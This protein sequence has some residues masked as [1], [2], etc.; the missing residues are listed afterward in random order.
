MTTTRLLA[1][2]LGLAA[3][4]TVATAPFAQAEPGLELT[5][6][7]PTG[8]HAIGTTSLHLVDHDRP[9]P[10]RPD[11]AREL[12]VTVTYPARHQS[13]DRAPW[14]SRAVAETVDSF[15]F[16]GQESPVTWHRTRR[17]AGESAPVDRARGGLPVVLFSPGL[18]VPRELNTVVTDDLA[19]RGYLVVSMSHTYETT[20]VEFPGGRVE[21]ADGTMDLK[22]SL[23]AR[24]GDTRF[25]LDKLTELDR[26]RNPDAGHRRL[27][28]GL[29][30]SLDL[31]RVGMFGHSYGGFTTAETMH[32]DRRID[33]GI[34][35]DGTMN[36]S[37][38]GQYLPGEVVKNG[39]DR[40]FALVGSTFLTPDG[41]RAD[42]NHLPGGLDRSW[43][44]FWANQQGWKRDL[45]VVDAGHNSFTDPQALMD[46][47]GPLLP[48][49]MRVALVGTIDPARSMAVQHNYL[50]AFFDLHLRGRDNH[51]LDGP[52]PAYPEV[53]FV[54]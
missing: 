44:E 25:V 14:M 2:G 33:A 32:Y 50:S 43:A 16:P 8:R 3:A 23:D 40:P 12:M 53:L 1:L 27:P 17:H 21:K 13:R 31:T 7:H 48:E 30:G 4:A 19:S 5:L 35:L 42:H 20:A 18:S 49:D 39:L 41:Q 47:L 11:R 46:Q 34:N 38:D 52:S 45:T 28:A 24:V 6:P 36:Y 9:D 10:W 26:G 29:R 51:L 15:L 37:A 22:K 54:E